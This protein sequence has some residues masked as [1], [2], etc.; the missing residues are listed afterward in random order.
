MLMIT[1]NDFTL[2]NI[3][4][5]YY[6]LNIFRYKFLEGRYPGT[7]K[8]AVA[9]KVLLDQFLMEPPLIVAFYMGTKFMSG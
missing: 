1:A 9:K 7:G 6:V 8:S 5:L 3:F 4:N 2:N